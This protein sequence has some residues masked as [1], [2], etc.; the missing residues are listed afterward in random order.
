MSGK[1][2]IPALMLMLFWALVSWSWTLPQ[3]AAAR[4]LSVSSTRAS[5]VTIPARGQ[6]HY[7]S[8]VSKANN[9]QKFA[10]PPRTVK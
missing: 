6:P 2:I 7:F 3:Q 1:S 8:R 4:P 10:S 9:R 5:Q